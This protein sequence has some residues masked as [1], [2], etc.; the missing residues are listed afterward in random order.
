MDRLTKAQM[1]FMNGY[2]PASIHDVY[3]YAT[4]GGIHIDPS[5][6]GT[7][8]AQAT[9]MNMGVQEAASHILANKDEY[10]SAMVKKANFARNFAKE[11]G[12]VARGDQ[13]N[14]QM[15]QMIQTYAQ[16]VAQQSGDDPNKV[17]Q[18]LM[19]QLQQMKPEQ[20]QQAIQQIVKQV[21]SA[22]QQPAMQ[23][24]G[25]PSQMQ[26]EGGDAEQLIQQIQQML[27]QGA[28]PQE[29]IAQLLQLQINPQM[30][31]EI[32]VQLGMPQEQ[33]VQAVQG[34]MQQMGGG[35]EQEN[36]QQQMQEQGME[37]PAPQGMEYGGVAKYPYGGMYDNKKNYA[38]FL[39]QDALNNVMTDV[40]MLAQPAAALSATGIKPLKKIA[41]FAGLASG[42]AGAFQGY[43]GVFGKKDPASTPQNPITNTQAT[44]VYN[45]YGKPG[46]G[47]QA[48]DMWNKYGKTQKMY[49]QYMEDGGLTK[50]QI[51]GEVKNKPK[52]G[53]GKYYTTTGD[54]VDWGTPEYEKAYNRGEVLSEDGVRSEV[55]LEGGVLPEVVLQNNY[56]DGFW[57][58]SRKKY[59]KDNEGAGLLSAIGSVATYPLSVP[60]HALTYLTTGKVQD[61]SEA[62]GHNTNEGWFDSP[63]AFGRNLDDAALNIILDPVNLIGAGILTKENALSKLGK[64]K[65]LP[66]ASKNLKT[67]IV[68]QLKVNKKNISNAENN[69]YRL[70][71]Y[72]DLT[73]KETFAHIK[74]GRS[75]T[76]PFSDELHEL[77]RA[78]ED[79]EAWKY[80]DLDE[81]IKIAREK[82]HQYREMADA[83]DLINRIKSRNPGTNDELVYYQGKDITKGRQE[84]NDFINMAEGNQ[85]VTMNSAADNIKSNKNILY[86]IDADDYI[87]DPQYKSLDDIKRAGQTDAGEFIN[88][89]MKPYKGKWNSLLNNKY[90]GLAKAQ[91]GIPPGFD[92][93]NPFGMQSPRFGQTANYADTR[94]YTN[95]QPIRDRSTSTYST[96]GFVEGMG[97]GQEGYGGADNTRYD[98]NDP[99][100]PTAASIKLYNDQQALGAA[101]Q[102]TI[103]LTDKEVANK[104]GKYDGYAFPQNAPET[105]NKKVNKKTANNKPFNN[106]SGRQMANNALLGLSIFN[107]S[108]GDD[109]RGPKRMTE[110]E[111]QERLLNNPLNYAGIYTPNVQGGGN[112]YIPNRYTATQD[113]GTTGNVIAKAGGQMNF[114]A[115]GQYKVSHE[116]LLQLLRDGAE[117]EF[118]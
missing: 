4:G 18:E 57:G 34:V 78:I 95:G 55:T 82:A 94:G 103:S 85:G 99:N 89:Y 88:S 14:A 25:D 59:I 56:K 15:M 52:L 17:Y 93:K 37:E 102:N 104:K 61:P 11:E 80:A 112:D 58:Q 90:G 36:P 33:V 1:E 51:K 84:L 40:N 38:N 65:K 114:A 71:D 68:E 101:G 19:G 44:N 98:L 43:R 41:G 87:H 26:Q 75:R 22:S 21:Q 10:S 7:F 62:W 115:G 46:A 27:Q 35:Q 106:I 111:R 49:G 32:F 39:P 96:P 23:M 77:S 54:I 113:Y 117:I 100:A 2:V 97:V 118:L 13:G 70:V 50:Y 74:A 30:I 20:Q 28:Q 64:I 79:G 24:G 9:R 116:Q 73:P 72:D 53:A 29:V 83:E 110:A 105:Y 3:E 31:V 86:E 8:K 6:K 91:V 67:N 16:M 48:S 63:A 45:T 66:N 60:Q 76:N 12:G 42:L 5:K 107:D 47:T 92:F 108:L 81:S 109:K 69:G